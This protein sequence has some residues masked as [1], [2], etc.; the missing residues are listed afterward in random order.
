MPWS[1]VAPMVPV[2]VP[3]LAVKT[4]VAPP[5]VRV[6]P[7]ASF[8]CSVRVTVAPAV[9]LL[10]DT[11]SRERAADAGPGVPV[12]LKVTGLPVSPA[13]VALSVLAPACWPSVQVLAAMPS[14]PVV[15]DAGETLPPPEA[16]AQVTSTPETALPRASRT[17]TAGETGSALPTRA[18][19]LSPACTATCAAGPGP[20]G[21]ETR[22]LL[23][24]VTSGIIASANSRR[25]NRGVIGSCVISALGRCG[26]SSTISGWP[27][28]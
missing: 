6:L 27:T 14:L 7:A 1:V 4:T 23:H 11:L 8:A 3:P 18:V 21:P 28:Q 25:A 24:V 2:L 12:A 16:T 19:W 13:T 10:A 22:S 20:C 26:E 5:A 9:T 17:T 15:T